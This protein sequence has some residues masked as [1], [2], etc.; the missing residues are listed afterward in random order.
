MMK[1][2]L[3]RTL[4]LWRAFPLSCGRLAASSALVAVAAST[5]SLA[6][7]TITDPYE[8]LSPTGSQIVVPLEAFGATQ[9]QGASSPSHQAA[10]KSTPGPSL[11]A[12]AGAV[13]R[14]QLRETEA[15]NPQLD[16][17]RRLAIAFYSQDYE[18][19]LSMIEGQY[20]NGTTDAEI[21]NIQ[22]AALAELHQH[23]QAVAIFK[24]VIEI[25]PKHF[26]ARFN[27]AEID[28]LEG[29]TAA[30]RA[31]FL[32]IKPAGDVEDEILDMKIALTY[33]LDDRP[34]DAKKVVD[35]MP[36]PASS[37]AWYVAQAALAFHANNR[38]EAHSYLA[39]SER[40][41]PGALAGFYLRTL[42]DAGMSP[43]LAEA[44]AVPA[45][46][47]IPDVPNDP[48]AKEQR[49]AL[50]LDLRAS[51]LAISPQSP[52]PSPAPTQP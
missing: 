37:P 12:V 43:T 17:F 33:L 32:A 51:D 39:S 24:Q 3:A 4:H 30:A 31:K 28:M 9:S 21:L 22:G 2:S 52:P 1:S 34:D 14:R 38:T 29:R 46:A 19:V 27:I 5:T 26:W 40:V 36:F 47:V 6:A 48:D 50:P 35:A 15:A 7:P 10:P 20:P 13:L 11:E 18:R 45:S 44:L 25:E 16:I 49:P 8:L 41:F 23:E 42:E